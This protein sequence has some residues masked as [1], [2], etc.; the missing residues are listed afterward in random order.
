MMMGMGAIGIVFSGVY[1]CASTNKRWIMRGACAIHPLLLVTADYIQ[2]LPSPVRWP[3]LDFTR[4][5]MALGAAG[6]FCAAVLFSIL[7]FR[8]RRIVHLL[9][10]V[11]VPIE[12][13]F[14]FLA[15]PIGPV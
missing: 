11:E 2:S 3:E 13:L 15:Y 14:I 1:W 10:I 7:R 9:L 5:H 8:G 4:F 12:L 6:V